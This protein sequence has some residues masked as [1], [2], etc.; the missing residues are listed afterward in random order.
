MTEKAES[1]EVEETNTE[2][3]VAEIK[4]MNRRW[5]EKTWLF[6]LSLILGSLSL[7][8]GFF[9]EFESVWQSALQT[10]FF[11]ISAGFFVLV[12]SYIFNVT[13]LYVL[14]E[15]SDREYMLSFLMQIATIIAFVVNTVLI[16]LRYSTHLLTTDVR[17]AIFFQYIKYDFSLTSL[18]WYYLFSGDK[19]W[20]SYN[21]GTEHA[22]TFTILVVVYLII[23]VILALTAF[24]TIRK[25]KN[26]F[27]WKDHLKY[28]LHLFFSVYYGSIVLVLLFKTLF[29]SEE[30]KIKESEYYRKFKETI[31][32]IL[33]P[34]LLTG[35][36]FA[37][38]FFSNYAYWF[39]FNAPW[40]LMF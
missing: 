8:G 35:L 12:I 10:L 25:I 37:L 20:F 13:W 32:F 19:F 31:I 6:V 38:F 26:S 36:F 3:L 39:L 9:V 2:E 30:I 11:L 27:V 40:P 29:S 14:K 33:V 18:P 24:L 21:L 34:I 1:A 4:E 7:V 28:I 23:A 17:G 15:K 16:L 22:Q 5:Y